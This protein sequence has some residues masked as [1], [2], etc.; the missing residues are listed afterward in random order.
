MRLTLAGHAGSLAVDLDVADDAR[1]ADLRPHLAAVTGRAE[2]A[3][4]AGRTAVPLAVDDVVLAEDHLTGEFPLLPGAVLRIGS[5]PP[6]LDRAALRA[7]RHLAVVAGPD[8]GGLVPLDARTVVGRRPRGSTRARPRCRSVVLDDPTLSERQVEVVPGRRGLRVRDLASRNGTMLVRA[9]HPDREVPIRRRGRRL[10]AGDRLVLGATVLELRAATPR[11][12]GR[13]GAR[14][15]TSL[16]SLDAPSTWIAPA[17]G[18]AVLAAA[19]GNRLL[20]VLAAV[21]PATALAGVLA[22]RCSAR[23]EARRASRRRGRPVGGAARDRV[24]PC[25]SRRTCG[26]R[27]WSTGRG[28]PGSV[29]TARGRATIPVR[30]TRTARAAPQP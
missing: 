19:T 13:R 1:L 27:R 21:G 5:G 12:P 18:A 4:S 23:L 7:A 24:P 3:G 25:R 2:L 14:P 30:P 6:D 9:R 29:R 15:R 22:G 28:R 10:V 16:T 11:P 8:A 17:A 26:R 20:L